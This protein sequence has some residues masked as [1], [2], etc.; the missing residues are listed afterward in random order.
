MI[1]HVDI[2]AFFASVEQVLD[3]NLAGKPVIVGGKADDR[4]V[5]ASASYEARALGV[6]TAMPIAQAARVCPEGV[7]LRGRFEHYNDFSRRVM[8]ILA[9]YSPA[10]EAASLD[11]AYLDL[12][13]CERLLGPP[14]DLA[15]RIKR[16]VKAE[17]GLNVSIGAGANK[18]VAKV[19]TALAKPNGVVIIW[20][21]YEA[22][23]F[24]PLPLDALPG[25]GR[26][27]I[28]RLAEYNLR[29]LADLRRVSEEVLVATF[30]VGGS[31]LYRHCRGL[32]DAPVLAR[33]R[34]KSISRETTFEE[35]TLDR[36][37]VEAMLHYLTERA[38]RDLRQHGLLARGVTVKL[39]YA[40][41]QTVS[42]SRTVPEA[43]DQDESLYRTAV[44]LWRR[45]YTRRVRVRLVGVSLSSLVAPDQRQMDL[46]REPT[47]RRRDRLYRSIDRV[48]DKY[49]FS[50]VTAGR[51]IELLPALE[52]DPEGFRLRTAC[53]T[54]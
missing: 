13:G 44:A 39:R 2:D 19:A 12:A 50:A 53:L 45:L 1:L 36:G 41:C 42:A 51:S 4:S 52:R 3:P 8:A 26:R 28:E 32:C 48:R 33:E 21:G 54:R 24:A 31:T 34:P 16:R 38:A 14:F 30:G 43:T 22:D 15:D 37:Y 7:F 11:E 35:D 18:L 47:R 9:D 10:I 40:D 27:S 23:F 29:T 25:L 49:G 5:V 46:F 6:K 20:P 17:T